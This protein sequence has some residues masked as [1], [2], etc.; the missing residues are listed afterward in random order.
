M[1]EETTTEPTKDELFD[2]MK[3][4]CFPAAKAVLKLVADA[5]VIFEKNDEQFD[6]CYNELAGKLN[7]LLME[8]GVRYS[9]LQF[10]FQLVLSP[11]LEIS[12]RGGNRIDDVYKAAM[13]RKFGMDPDELTLKDIETIV[14]TEPL[15]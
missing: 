15:P 9:E 11:F 3:A 6:A 8:S 2:E 1:S 5:E 14:Q 4:R 13:K 12:Q 7:A 10:I